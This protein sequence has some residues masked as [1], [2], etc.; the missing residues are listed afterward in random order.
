MKKMVISALM[1]LVL[2]SFASA[3]LVEFLSNSIIGEI[4]I[5]G[6][7]FYTASGENLIMNVQPS[8]TTKTINGI[9]EIDF[10][11]EEDLGGIDF[12]KPELEFVVD[13]EINN[14]SVSRGIELE[15]GYVKD[16]G[17]SV[18]ICDIQHIGITEDGEITVPCDG[19]VVPT[20]TKHFYYT[21]EGM[22][23]EYLEYKITTGKSYVKITGVVL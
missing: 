22:G 18:K 5:E 8:S 20:N 19:S 21:I 16:N 6:P 14:Y 3:G 13:L 2:V 15:F 11:M 9:E 17:N 1:G 23:D 10:I 4:D 7:V 12:Y